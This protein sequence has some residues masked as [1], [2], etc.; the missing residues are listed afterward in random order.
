MLQD[1]DVVVHVSFIDV[2]N[3]DVHDLLSD[4]RDRQD[5]KQDSNGPTRSSEIECASI[6]DVW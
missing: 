1:K 2:D 4:Y 5:D 3:D 6:R